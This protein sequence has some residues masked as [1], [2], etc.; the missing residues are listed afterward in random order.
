MGGTGG[1][2]VGSVEKGNVDLSSDKTNGSFGTE[3]RDTG[4]P[5]LLRRVEG[6]EVAREIIMGV[7]GWDVKKGVVGTRYL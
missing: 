6:Y 5:R 7:E 2:I 3:V 4:R 1:S